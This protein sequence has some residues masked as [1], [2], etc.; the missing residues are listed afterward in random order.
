V[1]VAAKGWLNTMG[2]CDEGCKRVVVSNGCQCTTSMPTAKLTMSSEGAQPPKPEHVLTHN[3]N[4]AAC[5]CIVSVPVTFITANVRI[6]FVGQKVT[7]WAGDAIATH[8][9]QFNCRLSCEAYL[10]GEFFH[11]IW[12]YRVA[13]LHRQPTLHA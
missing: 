10:A 5:G 6:S 8:L 2:E 11:Y 12:V 7:V 1:I 3:L 9:P 4:V 13:P